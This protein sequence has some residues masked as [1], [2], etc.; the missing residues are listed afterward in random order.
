[1]FT[2]TV[3]EYV[4]PAVCMLTASIAALY[5]DIRQLG[6]TI[7]IGVIRHLVV[8]LLIMSTAPSTGVK[9][10]CSTSQV[11]VVPISVENDGTTSGAG[12]RFDQRTI[13]SW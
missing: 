8:D 13:E 9:P 2:S 5:P 6:L 1:M 3:L 10:L 7:Q 11:H 12:L 4:G